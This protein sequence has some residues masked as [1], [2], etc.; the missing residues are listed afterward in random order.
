[1]GDIDK[2]VEVGGFVVPPD[3]I[4]ALDGVATEGCHKT[5]QEIIASLRAMLKQ[6]LAKGQAMGSRKASAWSIGSVWLP[7]IL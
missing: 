6:L 2:V 5:V 7:C 3:M 4:H 1:V